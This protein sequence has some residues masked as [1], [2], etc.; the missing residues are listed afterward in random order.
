MRRLWRLIQTVLGGY[1]GKLPRLL[2][3][4]VGI[5]PSNMKIP[6]FHL[7]VI[8]HPWPVIRTVTRRRRYL[9]FGDAQHGV[10]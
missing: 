3:V 8:T 2:A 9:G 5:I 6:A 4:I 1:S 10:V 7:A